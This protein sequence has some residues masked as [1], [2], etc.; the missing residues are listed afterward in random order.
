MAQLGALA[1]AEQTMVILAEGSQ[2]CISAASLA[3]HLDAIRQERLD[4]ASAPGLGLNEES[5]DWAS[6]SIG[7]VED[8]DGN[9][10]GVQMETRAGAEGEQ[11]TQS[12]GED[13]SWLIVARAG[14]EY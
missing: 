9:G 1:L 8:A 4:W 3:A 2:H 11:N 5:I 14:D 12:N 6:V 10:D 13:G 7:G